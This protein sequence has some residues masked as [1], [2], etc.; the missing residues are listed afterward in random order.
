MTECCEKIGSRTQHGS[1]A[2]SCLQE[3]DGIK[4]SIAHVNEKSHRWK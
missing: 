3:R 4:H 1:R 2:Q